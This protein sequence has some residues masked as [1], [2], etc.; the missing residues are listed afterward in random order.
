MQ[1]KIFLRQIVARTVFIGLFK[2]SPSLLA[3][4][5]P[6]VHHV[7]AKWRKLICYPEATS[8]NRTHKNKHS[9]LNILEWISQ[10]LTWNVTVQFFSL[11]SERRDTALWRSPHEGVLCSL[12]HVPG[13]FW[14]RYDKVRFDKNLSL[15][16]SVSQSSTSPRHPL[17]DSKQT[18]IRLHIISHWTQLDTLRCALTKDEMDKHI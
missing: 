18:D 10:S 14:P 5:L 1:R 3:G 17:W 4:L 9:S 13:I 2:V 15:Y 8:C 7:L 6:Y 11:N 16:D 12:R